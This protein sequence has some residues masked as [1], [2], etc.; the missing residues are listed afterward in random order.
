[1]KLKKRIQLLLIFKLVELEIRKYVSKNGENEDIEDELS[2][3][4]LYK[5]RLFPRV[6]NSTPERIAKET[7][8]LKKNLELYGRIDTE[9]KVIM[10]LS[11]LGISI[12]RM[13]Q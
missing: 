3:Y 1:M 4:K 2:L 7:K 12:K 9:D 8:F 10:A 5:K 11:L 13:K 6:F